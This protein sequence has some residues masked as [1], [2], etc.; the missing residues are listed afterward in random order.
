MPIL[1][2]V[3]IFRLMFWAV[4]FDSVEPVS[5]HYRFICFMETGLLI[6]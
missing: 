3:F 1:M 4:F 5:D 6:F 2:F